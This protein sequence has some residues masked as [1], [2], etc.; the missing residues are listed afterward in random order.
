MEL[1]SPKIKKFLYAQPL[2]NPPP[3]KKE[4]EKISYIFSKKYFSYTFGK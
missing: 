3:R 2:P 1:S 4:N